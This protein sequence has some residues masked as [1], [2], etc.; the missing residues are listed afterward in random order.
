MNP[1]MFLT[2]AEFVGYYFLII[3]TQR[4]VKFGQLNISGGSRYCIQI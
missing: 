2:G 4:D 1:A 3:S